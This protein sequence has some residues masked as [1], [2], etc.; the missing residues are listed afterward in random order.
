MQIFDNK[1]NK[2]IYSD[3]LSG[4][5]FN[6]TGKGGITILI[7]RSLFKDDLSF[8][9]AVNTLDDRLDEAKDNDSYCIIVNGIEYKSIS[10]TQMG[11]DAFGSSQINDC[12]VF[13]VSLD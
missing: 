7:K 2:N 4:F 1:E 12:A 6:I 3:L 9:N 8:L 11:L 5:D 10:Y 13:S